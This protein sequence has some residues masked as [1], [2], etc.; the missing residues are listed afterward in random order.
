[1]IDYEDKYKVL[2]LQMT[3]ISYYKGIMR[4]KND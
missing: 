3:F 4:D 1:M 2:L